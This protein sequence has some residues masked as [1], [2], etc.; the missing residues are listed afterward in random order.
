MKRLFF[1][2]LTV[3]LITGSMA[4]TNGPMLTWEKSTY[5]FGDVVQ[6]EK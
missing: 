5:D 2:I 4:Q 1:S 3:F 6:G